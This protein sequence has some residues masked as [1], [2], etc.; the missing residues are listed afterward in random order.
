MFFL[1]GEYASSINN[2]IISRIGDNRVFYH[3]ITRRIEYIGVDRVVYVDMQ[4]CIA[5]IGELDALYDVETGRLSK[6]GA[7]PVN[8]DETTGFIVSIGNNQVFYAESPEQ[9]EPVEGAYYSPVKTDAEAQK[10][11]NTIQPIGLS[12]ES[13]NRQRMA[14]FITALST[15]T[16][17]DSALFKIELNIREECEERAKNSHFSDGYCSAAIA[18]GAIK[19]LV[20]LMGAATP[21]TRCKAQ[22]ALLTLCNSVQ[23]DFR[24]DFLQQITNETSLIIDK[25]MTALSDLPSTIE[26][27]NALE[28]LYILVSV[29]PAIAI[30]LEKKVILFL[31]T[32]R[33]ENDFFKNC[34]HPILEKIILISSDY[35]NAVL[36]AEKL[37]KNPLPFNGSQLEVYYIAHSFFTKKKGMFQ[38][39]GTDRDKLDSLLKTLQKGA[40]KKP[41]GASEQTL[42]HFGVC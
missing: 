13:A 12:F 21:S 35:K 5:K 14:E 4:G 23:D 27:N 32:K 15:P 29:T 24:A 7:I 22:L 34:I 10:Y 1:N 40:E 16:I 9:Y 26:I 3:C 33:N 18:L 31:V 30:I 38:N 19:K 41:G 8:Y 25:M 28:L 37:S 20:V 17:C 36:R 11:S 39:V 42:N 2:R 6:I